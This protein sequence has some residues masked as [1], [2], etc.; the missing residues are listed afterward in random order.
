MTL[1][2]PRC[3]HTVSNAHEPQ[4][5]VGSTKAELRP[6]FDAGGWKR[7]EGVSATLEPGAPSAAP[8]QPGPAPAATTGSESTVS[9]P[10]APKNLPLLVNTLLKSL[11]NPT[12]AAGVEALAKMNLSMSEKKVAERMQALGLWQPDV[13]DASQG[14][15]AGAS[16]PT[17]SSAVE[18]PAGGA[19]MLTP[20]PWKPPLHQRLRSMP[21]FP[22]LNC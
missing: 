22:S 9:A 12:P 4:E 13:K 7:T 6:I 10:G 15:T 1:Q 8:G 14:L 17:T 18:T 21:I 3:T 20:R 19:G 2:L 5:T 11:H 16:A